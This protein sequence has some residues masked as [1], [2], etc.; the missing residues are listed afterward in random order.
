[1]DI[2]QYRPPTSPSCTPNIISV[3]KQNIKTIVTETPSGEILKYDVASELKQSMS[4]PC[5]PL[6]Q[7]SI[8]PSNGP[9]KYKGE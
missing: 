1:M 7:L 3:I 5:S 6:Q 9:E 4:P 2:S 8:D